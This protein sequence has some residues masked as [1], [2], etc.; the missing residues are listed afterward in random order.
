MFVLLFDLDKT[1]WVMQDSCQ[2]G[3]AAGE[4]RHAAGEKPETVHGKGSP[5]NGRSWKT[6][7]PDAGQ[8]WARDKNQKSIPSFSIIAGKITLL[9]L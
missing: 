1:P 9:N 2:K 6:M 8:A 5:E 4:T 7:P 3:F